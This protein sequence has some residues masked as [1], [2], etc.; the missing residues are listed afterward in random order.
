MERESEADVVIIGADLAGLVAGAIL[1]RHGKRVVILE[2]ADTIGG[3]GGAVR[4]AD[5]FW[6]DF[7]HRD[8][9]GVGDCQFPWHHGAAAARE[10]GR[11]DH[12]A[13]DE[14]AAPAACL[15]DGGVIDGGNWSA[16]GFSARRAS[17]SIVPRTASPISGSAL[18]GP[19]PRHRRR[20]S[21]RRLPVRRQ[22]F[23]RQV[24]RTRGAPIVL[25][26]AAVIFHPRPEEASAGG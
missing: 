18:A 15:S 12:D 24:R 26:M 2:Q 19:S 7:G 4:T 9:H 5:G 10:A 17:S 16:G 21:R 1:T 8:A 11:R 3:R 22:W 25:L 13:T 14:R 23:E 20:K 6:I